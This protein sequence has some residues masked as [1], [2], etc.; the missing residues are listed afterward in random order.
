M[1]ARRIIISDDADGTVW[2]T[3]TFIPLFKT[4][5]QPFYDGAL[6]QDPQRLS[7]ARNGNELKVLWYGSRTDDKIERVKGRIII[8]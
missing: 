8:E 7:L 6:L 3:D 1:T 2:D 4:N 5:T